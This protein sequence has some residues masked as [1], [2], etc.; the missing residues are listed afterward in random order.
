MRRAG[1]ERSEQGLRSGNVPVRPSTAE[2][3]LPEKSDRT[4]S[5]LGDLRAVPLQH[6]IEE[7]MSRPSVSPDRI[8]VAC[9]PEMDHGYAPTKRFPADVAS[10]GSSDVRV[11]DVAPWSSP[12]RAD[13]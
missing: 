13:S 2:R 10:D 3:M 12:L 9:V 7:E 6:V 11:D 8:L 4:L 5:S 1:I